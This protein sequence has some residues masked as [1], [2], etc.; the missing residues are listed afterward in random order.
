MSAVTPSGAGPELRPSL[1][2]MLRS[3]HQLLALSFGLG[4]S[5]IAPGTMGSI[6]GIA[7]FAALAQVPLPVRAALYVILIAAASWAATRTGNDL[8]RHDHNSIV[9]DETIGMSLTLEAAPL[10]AEAIVLAF[11]LFRLFDVWKP[12]PVYLPDRHGKSGLAVIGDDILA[13]GWA[14]AV[15]AGLTWAGLL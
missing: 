10:S 9:I 7:L 5:R 1:S 14:A 6:G 11:L 4:L 8:N 3:P 12:W 15:L 2:G 13:A